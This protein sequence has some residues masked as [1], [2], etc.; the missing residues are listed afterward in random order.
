MG[1]KAQMLDC[2]Q[3][4]FNSQSGSI[5]NIHALVPLGVKISTNLI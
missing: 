1:T 2:W 5:S 3:L 4:E